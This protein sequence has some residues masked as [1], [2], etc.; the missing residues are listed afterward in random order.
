MHER[1]S[2]PSSARRTLGDPA[3]RCLFR[4]LSLVFPHFPCD[5]F[6]RDLCEFDRISCLAEATKRRQECRVASNQNPLYGHNTRVERHKAHFDIRPELCVRKGKQVIHRE[7]KTFTHRSAAERWEKSPG[8]GVGKPGRFGA[9]PARREVT[10]PSHP[11]VH[12]RVRLCFEVT[13]HEAMPVEI[14]RE[15]PA[16]QEQCIRPLLFCSH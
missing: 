1:R 7:T 16:R 4:C 11:L 14:P 12:R 8:G 15:A 2:S 5:A 9:S 13:A 6:L 10:G 3:K